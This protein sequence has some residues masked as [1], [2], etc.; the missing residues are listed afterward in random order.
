M[1]REVKNLAQ[2]IYDRL[3]NRAQLAKRPF[4]WVLQ[5]YAN[6]RFLYRLSKSEHC[7]KFVLKGGLIFVGWEIPLRRHTTDIDFRVFTDNSVENIRNIIRDIC[8]QQVE[9]DGMS[10]E[11]ALITVDVILEQAEYPGVRV[12]FVG[13]LGDKTKVPMQIDMGFSDEITPQPIAIT[14]PT[15]LDM[16]SPELRG[17]PKETV[18]AEKLH[19][20]VFRGSI[21]SRRKDFYDIW[22]MSQQFDFDGKL[23][24]AAITE[25]FNNRETS[26]PNEL[27]IALTTQYAKDNQKQWEGFLNTFNP[28]TTGI[29]NFSSVINSLREFLFPVLLASALDEI[30]D[31]NWSCAQSA[32]VA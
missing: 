3:R 17:Y 12:R 15:L 30:F 20:L 5:S 32:W 29:A 10:F 1:N 22:F 18:V 28:N 25:T 24:Q 8:L 9:D 23:L 19:C 14:Y 13:R 7:Q 21:N 31:R 4:D 16:P 6:E 27:P 11:P 2:S 26:I